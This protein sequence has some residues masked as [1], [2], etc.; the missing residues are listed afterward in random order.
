VKNEELEWLYRLLPRPK[1]E[2]RH[3]RYREQSQGQAPAD[4]SCRG[5]AVS[6]LPENNMR[7]TGDY[8]AAIATSNQRGYDALARRIVPGFTIRLATTGRLGDAG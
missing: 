4:F 1:P 3:F 2:A 7:L 5:D 6:L 8:T